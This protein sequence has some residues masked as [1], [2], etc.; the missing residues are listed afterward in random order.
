ME[1]EKEEEMVKESPGENTA[2]LDTRGRISKAEIEDD[3][4]PLPFP[5]GQE[6]VAGLTRV[7]LNRTPEVKLQHRVYQ[8]R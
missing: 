6:R 4:E 2:H 8:R 7:A 3:E 5:T 1:S